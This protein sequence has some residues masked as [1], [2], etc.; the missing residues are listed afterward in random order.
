MSRFVKMFT[1]TRRVV[2]RQTSYCDAVEISCCWLLRPCEAVAANANGLIELSLLSW[3]LKGTQ[4][5]FSPVPQPSSRRSCYG[6]NSRRSQG[7]SASSP[8]LSG[9]VR[10]RTRTVCT[11]N[12]T[13]G[14][15]K[16]TGICE[17][18]H[19]RW[20]EILWVCVKSL[21]VHHSVT[22]VFIWNRN[23]RTSEKKI[24]NKFNAIVGNELTMQSTCK[25]PNEK[26]LRR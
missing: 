20:N 8:R 9:L 17:N 19:E 2:K 22:G 26:K 15:E 5:R 14:Q 3:K 13:W 7:A 21:S 6:G 10:P 11:W 16:Y 25:R 24:T 4:V 23:A 1:Y 12:T 18:T